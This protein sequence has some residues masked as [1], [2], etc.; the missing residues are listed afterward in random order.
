MSW[1]RFPRGPVQTLPLRSQTLKKRRGDDKD[2]GT[3]SRLGKP[4]KS[5]N[6]G[7][8]AHMSHSPMASPSPVKTR[9]AR[10]RRRPTEQPSG[11]AVAD[12]KTQR[13]K[14]SGKSNKIKSILKTPGSPR[15][16][17][18]KL[19]FSPKLEEY[20]ETYSKLDYDR[21]MMANLQYVCDLCMSPLLAQ[22]RF[23]C[24][25]KGCEFDLCSEC[26]C[27]FV[28]KEHKKSFHPNRK[29]LRF[30]RIDF[31]DDDDE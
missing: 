3:L 14:D 24:P 9:K 23:S 25:V 18:R 12:A 4:S 19:V 5:T 6:E 22:T 7:K 8:K 13:D 11:S 1:R 28:V 26:Y 21:S 17:K 27:A 10:K 15:R 16:K 2:E 29:K 20:G 30:K 31:E